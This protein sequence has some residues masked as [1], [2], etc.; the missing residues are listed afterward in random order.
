MVVVVA[1]VVAVAVAV[2][3]AVA[4]TVGAAAA[5]VAAIAAAVAVAVL[6]A[7]VV[8]VAVGVRGVAVGTLLRVARAADVDYAY[9]QAGTDLQ[10]AWTAHSTLQRRTRFESRP[11]F[12]SRRNAFLV[13][14][15][16][17]HTMSSRSSA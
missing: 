5:A 15:R 6:V 1:V 2:A 10:L 9:C 7:V 11:W 3:S 4:V 13:Q 17:R 8:L 14:C 16:R 12:A